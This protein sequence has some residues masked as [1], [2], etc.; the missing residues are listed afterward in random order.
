[1]LPEIQFIFNTDSVGYKIHVIL[2]EI[3]YYYI[4]WQIPQYFL[5]DAY[6]IIHIINVSC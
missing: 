2:T 4:L 6:I 3:M 1:M 5:S